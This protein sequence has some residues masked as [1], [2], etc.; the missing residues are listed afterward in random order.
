MC[1]ISDTMYFKVL[2]EAAHISVL[3]IN[4]TGT[5]FV[6][7]TLLITY[8]RDHFIFD[9][10]SSVV[11]APKRIAMSIRYFWNVEFLLFPTIYNMGLKSQF[12][13][14]IQLQR[15]FSSS[16]R[17]MLEI[18]HLRINT[19]VCDILEAIELFCHGFL[20]L[21]ALYTATPCR[22]VPGTR[23]LARDMRGA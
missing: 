7:R 2:I 14:N 13:K 19:R 16:K 15:V 4:S 17:Y 21:F 6:S 8:I 18:L 9:L 3:I 10:S 11:L 5:V 12:E 22:V 1:D 20:N 23:G